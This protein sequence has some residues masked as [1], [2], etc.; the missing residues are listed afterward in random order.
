MANKCITQGQLHLWAPVAPHQGLLQVRNPLD[1]AASVILVQDT[2]GW[3]RDTWH[4][5][6]APTSVSMP[7]MTP[8]HDSSSLVQ[9][10]FTL[11]WSSG[12][13]TSE[14]DIRMPGHLLPQ[15]QNIRTS[16]GPPKLPLPSDIPRYPNL[17]EFS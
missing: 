12:S 7:M 8:T 1:Q 11:A 9:W 3:L 15:D 14:W 6:W 4:L 10:P 2:P 16:D 17:E 5:I 13:G